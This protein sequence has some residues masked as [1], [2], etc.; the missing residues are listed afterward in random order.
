MNI[1]DYCHNVKRKI[2]FVIIL[3]NLICFLII[4]FYINKKDLNYNEYTN[5]PKLLS[6]CYILIT[7]LIMLIHSIY[8]KIAFFVIKDN[9]SILTNDKGKV[10][11]ILFIGILFWTSNNRIHTLFCIVNF[12]SFFILLLC[13]YICDCKFVIK[14]EGNFNNNDGNEKK[15]TEENNISKSNNFNNALI[16]N[17]HIIQKQKKNESNVPFFEN[18]QENYFENIKQVN[19]KAENSTKK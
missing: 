2:Q 9:F 1:N 18:I 6:N 5:L 8:P 19:L 12:I 14:L 11:I 10:I 3:I 17:Q 7:L 15:N 4:S 13:E 16:M